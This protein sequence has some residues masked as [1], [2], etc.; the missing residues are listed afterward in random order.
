MNGYTLRPYRPGEEEAINQAFCHVFR[1]SRTLTEWRWKFFGQG[2]PPYIMLAV[3]ER[4]QVLAQYAAVPVRFQTPLGPVL[5]GQVVDVFSIPQARIGLAAGRAYLE[6]MAHFFEEWGKPDHLAI[7]FGFPSQRPLKLGK[8]TGRYSQIPDQP[9]LRLR[10]RAQPLSRFSEV[11]VTAVWG[12]APTVLEDLWHEHG[13]RFPYAAIRNAPY[14][15]WRYLKKPGVHYQGLTVFRGGRPLASLILRH[16]GNVVA[17]VDWASPPDPVVWQQL[18]T[19]VVRSGF[20]REAQGLEAW[21]VGDDPT[22]EALMALGFSCEPHDQV[23]LAVRIF[24]PDLDPQL[25][26]GRFYV[27]WGDSDLI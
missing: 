4:C 13:S 21:L 20:I 24:H 19:G 14:F 7:L 8:L 18:L 11:G 17:L 22:A 1:Q 26:P 3:G 10:W 25:L 2:F 27:T 5:A 12:I 16:L 15:R 23:R 9:V 6:A